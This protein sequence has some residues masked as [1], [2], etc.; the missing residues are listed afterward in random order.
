M[1]I[2]LIRHGEQL[3]PYNDQGK[4]MVSDSN[5]PLVEL[6][7]KQIQQIG[8]KLI[9]EGQIIEAVYGS[10][11]LRTKQS[12]QK[13]VDIMRIPYKQEVDELREVDPCSGIGVTYE[14]LEERA[15]DIYA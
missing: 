15:G 8:E 14:E 13:L 6:G 3:Y 9:K 7:R 10:P 5:A 11:I 4:K 12:M 1:K 2:F